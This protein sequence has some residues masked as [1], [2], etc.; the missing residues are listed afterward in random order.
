MET[1]DKPNVTI[2]VDAWKFLLLSEDFIYVYEE[3]I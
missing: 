3:I 1:I 2:E